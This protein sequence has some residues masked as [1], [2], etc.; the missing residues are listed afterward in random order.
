[1]K[2]WQKGEMIEW[3]RDGDESE[4]EWECIHMMEVRCVTRLCRASG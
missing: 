4:W 3:E 2:G 1:M